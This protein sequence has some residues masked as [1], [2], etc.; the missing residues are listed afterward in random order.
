MTEVPEPLVDENYR[1]E[2]LTIIQNK[3]NE[4][5]R[6]AQTLM[7]P[8]EVGGCETKI[9]FK[10][11]YGG[12]SDNDGGWAASKGTLLHE[13]LDKSVFGPGPSMMPDGSQRWYSD[14]KLDQVVPWVTGG[15]LDLYDRLYQTVIDWKAPGDYTMKAVR[16]GKVSFGYYVQANIYGL[17]LEQMGYPVSR[18]ALMFLPMC[19]DELHGK[20]K[21]A[22]F[23]VWPYERSVALKAL[24]NIKR[25]QDVINEVGITEAL[26][27]LPKRS[28]FCSTCVAFVG[29]G[30]RRAT[31]AGMVER[32]IN[33]TQAPSGNPFNTKG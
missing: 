13:W 31:C 3:I 26:E 7:G 18:V 17:G 32:G 10:L 27:T 9:A 22:I 21:G 5:P 25:I 4:H 20:A 19:G 23:K 8:S 11:A 30:D 28:D 33:R 29:N 1:R 6:S 14:L 16:D 12:E 2:L 15:T 24:G